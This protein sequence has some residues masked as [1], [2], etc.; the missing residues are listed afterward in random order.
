[1]DKL[2]DEFLET[3]A[4]FAVKNVMDSGQCNFVER[5]LNWMMGKPGFGSKICL[6]YTW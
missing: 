1:V 5:P 4:I 3:D 6:Q 2:I